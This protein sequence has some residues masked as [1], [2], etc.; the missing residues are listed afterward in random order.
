MAQFEPDNTGDDRIVERVRA[1]V[2][3]RWLED[4]DGIYC[5]NFC[6]MLNGRNPALADTLRPLLLECGE[7]ATLR[8]LD[9]VYESE[10]IPHWADWQINSPPDDFPARL[11]DDRPLPL[12]VGDPVEGAVLRGELEALTLRVRLTGILPE[13]GVEV[14]LNDQAVP[15]AGRSEHEGMRIGVFD[16]SG[17]TWLECPLSAGGPLPRQGRNEVR[18]RPGVGSWG[19]LS[20]LVREVQLVVTYRK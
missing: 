10:A 2:S 9:K 14:F 18:A 3:N 11:V 12:V 7:P 15:V 20:T 8:G 13:E 6:C 1:A 4:P 19:R 5:F 17:G 16:H